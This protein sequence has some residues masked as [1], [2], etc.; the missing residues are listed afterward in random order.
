MSYNY[1]NV[2]PQRL[3]YL[4]KLKRRLKN[5]GES[6]RALGMI[7]EVSFDVVNVMST[8]VL[9]IAKNKALNHYTTCYY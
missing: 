5:T 1:G 6:F 3:N 7:R 8:M 9:F 2:K 4:Q